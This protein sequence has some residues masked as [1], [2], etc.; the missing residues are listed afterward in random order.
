MEP[1]L[2]SERVVVAAPMSLAGAFGRVRRLYGDITRHL[3]DQPAVEYPVKVL[4]WLL[5]V[6]VLLVWWSIVLAWY[7]FWGILLIPY[8]LIRRGSRK[9]KVTALQHRETLSAM[10]RVSWQPTHQVP[11]RGTGRLVTASPQRLGRHEALGESAATPGSDM[12]SVGKS[13]GGKRVDGLGGCLPA[14]PAGHADR[15]ASNACR[16]ATG[17]ASGLSRASYPAGG[18]VEFTVPQRPPG[19]STTTAQGPRPGGSAVRPAR[20]AAKCATWGRPPRSLPAGQVRR[21]TTTPSLPGSGSPGRGSGIRYRAV[22]TAG[23]GPARPHPGGRAGRGETPQDQAIGRGR[24]RAD[25]SEGGPTVQVGP[26][27]RG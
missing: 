4:V 11:P 20:A 5:C 12:G 2:A 19:P 8:R 27:V 13:H 1:Q 23:P 7:V 25:R 9:R 15:P 17:R 18:A 21:A 10:G 3:P 26:P 24:Q 14:V 16:S 22:P 6:A